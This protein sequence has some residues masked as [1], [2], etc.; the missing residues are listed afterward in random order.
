MVRRLLSG[1]T[2]LRLPVLI[3]IS[4]RLN[5]S[6]FDLLSDTD[7]QKALEKRIAM[8]VQGTSHPEKPIPWDE[9]KEKLRL[10]S[11][12]HPPPALEAVAQRM[13]YYPARLEPQLP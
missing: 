11:R 6:P 8:P 1:E 9:V 4:S 5:I 7:N 3:Q 13:G 2:K 12:E 10:A